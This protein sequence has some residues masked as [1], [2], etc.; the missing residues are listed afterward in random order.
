MENYFNYFTEIE[1][2]FQRRRGGVLLLSTHRELFDLLFK[3]PNPDAGNG[4]SVKPAAGTAMPPRND[5]AGGQ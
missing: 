3:P 5:K 1:E 2:A 4:N